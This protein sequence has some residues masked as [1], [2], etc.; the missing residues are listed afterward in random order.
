MEKNKIAYAIKLHIK[1][2]DETHAR[3]I[4]GRIRKKYLK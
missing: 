3:V 1:H 2:F 4:N